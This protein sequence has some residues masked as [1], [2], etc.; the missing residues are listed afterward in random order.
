MF[1]EQIICLP[2]T[3]S[4]NSEALR[5]IDSHKAGTVWTTNYQTAGRGQAGNTWESAPGENLCFSILLKPDFLQAKDQFLLSKC[6][7][8]AVCAYL[9]E[10][11]IDNR[12]KWPNDIY[13]DDRKI[14]GILLEHRIRGDRICA[15]VAGIG[16]NMNQEHFAPDIPNPASVRTLG[17]KTLNPREELPKVL[18]QFERLFDALGHGARKVIN[19]SYHNKLYTLNTWKTF[20]RLPSGIRFEGKICGVSDSGRLLVKDR[21]NAEHAF[22]FK[23]IRQ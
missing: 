18:R 13:A 3:D 12:I 4:T 14:A 23:E 10:I 5:H 11:G 17:G 16:L 2:E 9:Q 1:L 7:A 21:Q 8:L 6:A 15:S 19:E 22:A 20:T